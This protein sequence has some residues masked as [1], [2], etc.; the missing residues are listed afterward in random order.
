MIFFSLYV[1]F[2]SIYGKCFDV[3]SQCLFC[4]SP[5]KVID[6]RYSSDE[7]E[8]SYQEEEVTQVR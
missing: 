2:C 6:L 8:D 7:T 1:E 5:D 3:Q 4:L